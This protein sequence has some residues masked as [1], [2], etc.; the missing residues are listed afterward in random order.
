MDNADAKTLCYRMLNVLDIEP[1]D[2]VDLGYI[3]YKSKKFNVCLCPK[4]GKELCPLSRPKTYLN[5]LNDL[6]NKFTSFIAFIPNTH[7]NGLLYHDIKSIDNVF[8]R[9]SLEEIQIMLDLEIS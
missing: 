2:R 3:V 6:C 4:H 5:V 7:D 1:V 8:F 9:K